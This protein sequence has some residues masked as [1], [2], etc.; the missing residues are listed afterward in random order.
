MTV[1]IPSCECDGAV[2]R[3]RGTVLPY[4]LKVGE[5]ACGGLGG[6]GVA[7]K[8]LGAVEK[9][10]YL[11]D[12]FSQGQA[13]RSL[14]QIANASGLSKATCHRTLQALQRYGLLEREGEDYS[15]GYRLLELA[16]NV[17]AAIEPLSV[18]NDLMEHLRDEV[19]ESVQLVVRSGDEV[20][21]AEV[22][23]PFS[24]SR[25]YVRLG[26][27]APLYAGA[28]GRLL[29]AALSDGQIAELLGRVELLRYTTRTPQSREAVM[30]DVAATRETWCTRSLGELERYSAEMA[31]PI[32]GAAGNVVAALS[33]AGSDKEYLKPGARKAML[34][35]LDATAIGISRRLGYDAAWPTKPEAFLD[36]CAAMDVEAMPAGADANV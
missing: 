9:A 20:V 23:P 1:Y 17:N 5:T 8:D 28:S 25:L 21:Y 13:Q 24:P 15:L 7:E 29:L 31:V 4:L 3:D 18:G 2:L 14:T 22:L 6:W 19:D 27:R 35:A 26:R 12:F 36:A 30:Q 33:L 16:A 11:L 34:L 10:L 32:L